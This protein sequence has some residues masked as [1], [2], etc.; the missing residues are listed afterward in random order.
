MCSSS[1]LRMPDHATWKGLWPPAGESESLSSARAGA[2]ALLFSQLAKAIR[3]H[4]L[5][6]EDNRIRIEF[7]DRLH[8]EFEEFLRR[9]GNLNVSVQETTFTYQGRVVHCEPDL[10]ISLSRC[11][12][13]ATASEGWSSTMASK[14]LRW[15]ACS[16]C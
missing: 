5:Y 7:V 10:R 6:P 12:S 13:S 2:T 8:R 15:L 1:A 14:D 4:H 9:F 11:V 3:I 16:R